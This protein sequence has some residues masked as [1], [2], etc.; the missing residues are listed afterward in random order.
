MTTIRD[1]QGEVIGYFLT[2]ADYERIMIEWAKLKYP[3][4]ELERRDREPGPRRT[5]AEILADLEKL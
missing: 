1:D 2:R 4:E 5:T 3:L